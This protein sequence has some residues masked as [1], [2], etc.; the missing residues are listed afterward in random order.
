MLPNFRLMVAATFASVVVLI[1][2]FGV[3][4]AF[5]V[6][7]APLGRALS[8]A[9]F[10]FVTSTATAA[11]RVAA[12]AEPFADRFQIDEGGSMAGV[13]A[14]AYAAPQAAEPA[15]V[16]FFAA[17]AGDRDPDATSEPTAT[18]NPDA[19]KSSQQAAIS[20]DAPETKSD[21]ASA[22]TDEQAT[23]APARLAAAEAPG[24]ATVNIAAGN[25]TPAGFGPANNESAPEDIHEATLSSEPEAA[26]AGLATEPAQTRPDAAAKRGDKVS[27]H[28]H[29][30]SKTHRGH[31]SR[32]APIDAAFALGNTQSSD[33]WQP[34]A[35]KAPA[36]SRRTRS[37]AGARAA[38]DTA[39]GGPFVGMPG[40]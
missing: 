11:S 36:K 35:E 15:D 4:A 3:F 24:A 20:A 29:A 33:A 38:S 23:P 19:P 32:S 6:S 27:E 8:T 16:K 40:R 28:L 31:K 5:S 30:A 26:P 1:F 14:L 9:P 37:A 7:H 25:G 18:D 12:V 10:R 17:V 39:I 2:G 22:A 21:G 34:E 13:S